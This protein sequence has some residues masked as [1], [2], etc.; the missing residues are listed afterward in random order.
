MTGPPAG[1]V[2]QRQICMLVERNHNPSNATALVAMQV[3][4]NDQTERS[5]PAFIPI[6][7]YAKIFRSPRALSPPLGHSFHAWM[8]IAS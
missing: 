7:P 3:Q 1:R 2:T 6:N 8:Q 5:W 4:N